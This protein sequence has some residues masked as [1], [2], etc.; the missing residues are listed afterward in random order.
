MII[1]V[2]KFLK[3]Q[4]KFSDYILFW[5]DH[6]KLL[7]QV[8]A[9]LNEIIKLLKIDSIYTKEGLKILK[10]EIRADYRRAKAER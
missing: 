6:S 9:K 8:K 3:R 5:N 7:R 4:H 10:N 2:K 1:R